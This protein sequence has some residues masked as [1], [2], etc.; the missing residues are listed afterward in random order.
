M[1]EF[2]LFVSDYDG[3]LTDIK[4]MTVVEDNL[5]TLKR[6]QEKG[7]KVVIASGRNIDALKDLRGLKPDYYICNVGST[8][9]DADKKML[10]GKYM[11]MKAFRK[12]AFYALT[13][14]CRINV[15][16]DN[17][18]RR[19]LSFK[20]IVNLFNYFKD[21]LTV[22]DVPN[23]MSL[24]STDEV[25]SYIYSNFAEYFESVSGGFLLDLTPNGVSK[26]ETLKVLCDMIGID[27]KEVMSFGDSENDL[28]LIKTAGVGVAV[29]NAEEILKKNADYVTTA[30]TNNGVLNALKHFNILD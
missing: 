13:H 29:E 14:K 17:T 4:T 25:T 23:S 21:Y 19:Y 26:G 30:S 9:Y 22:R 6:L 15:K 12:V 8:I 1:S 10:Y 16:Y 7:Y 20:P 28:T 27:T 2:K 11:D 3:T 5:N 18:T 24:W